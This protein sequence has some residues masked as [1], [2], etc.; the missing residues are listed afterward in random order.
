MQDKHKLQKLNSPPMQVKFIKV[1]TFALFVLLFHKAFAQK[2]GTSDILAPNATVKQIF[3][4]ED[5]LEGPA[6]SHDG[7]LY[8]SEFPLSNGK[9]GKAGIIWTLNPITGES[10]V[11]RSPVV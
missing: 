5:I 9:P 11:F 8:F 10:K 2:T 1:L 3:K 7:I 4:G 6:M